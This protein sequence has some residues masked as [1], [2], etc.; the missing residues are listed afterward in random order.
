MDD[1]AKADPCQVLD[2]KTKT[3]C[4]WEGKSLSMHLKA[5]RNSKNQTLKLPEY[6]K[7]FPTFEVGPPAYMPPPE[8][9]AKFR[10]ASSRIAQGEENKELRA[11]ELATKEK[12]ERKA[13]IETE[14]TIEA[15]FEELWGMC[16]R[17]PAARMFCRS[18]AK[19]EWLLQDAYDRADIVRLRPKKSKTDFD[20]LKHLNSEIKEVGDRLQKSMTSL[21]L[22]VEQRRKSNQLGSDTVSQLICNFAN[23]VRK[24]SDEK[25]DAFFRRIN[26]VRATIQ[27]R[28]RVNVL[29]EVDDAF[30][31][32]EKVEH[33]D[34]YR[35]AIKRFSKKT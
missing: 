27:E 1:H 9:V 28:V 23:T 13:T 14:N 19:D 22:T 18:A 5:H 7:R 33:D 4:G 29:T 16:E 30:D 35:A 2:S 21:S 6:K 34:D 15:R 31:Q 24:M 12:A 11:K 26:S 25:Q 32:V 8:Q 17:D 3:I 10:G 20:D